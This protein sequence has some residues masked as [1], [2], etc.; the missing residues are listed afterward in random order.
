MH[1]TLRKLWETVK[2]REAWYAA[3]HGLFTYVCVLSHSVVSDSMTPWTAACQAPLSMGIL[4]AGIPEW[5]AMP[6]SRKSS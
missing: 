1:M 5:I 2:V 4:Q 3:V 6:S